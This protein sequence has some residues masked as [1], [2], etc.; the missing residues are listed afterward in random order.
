M[1]KVLIILSCLIILAGGLYYQYEKAFFLEEGWHDLEELLQSPKT[2]N[3]SLAKWNVTW[4]EHIFSPPCPLHQ[5]LGFQLLKA[6]CCQPDTS[7][8][9]ETGP[10]RTAQ[11]WI[12]RTYS[13]N[14]EG[15]GLAYFFPNGDFYYQQT[16]FSKA[17]RLCFLVNSENCSLRYYDNTA[18]QW[19]VQIPDGEPAPMTLLYLS[20]DHAEYILSP[21]Y[22]YRDATYGCL[23][24]VPEMD[25]DVCVYPLD[26]ET[27]QV[28]IT[29]PK[30]S[31][32]EERYWWLLASEET[33]VD[34]TN[35]TMCRLWTGYQFN[36]GRWCGTGFYSKKPTSYLPEG[37]NLYFLNP[38]SYIPCNF[39]GTGG[40]RAADDLGVT[41]LDIVRARYNDSYFIPI[42]TESTMLQSRY[43]IGAGYFD[44]R[45]N[46]DI[47]LAY[48]KAAEKFGIAEF[49]AT[50]E[51][52]AK[53]LFWHAE[54]HGFALEGF[55]EN[56]LLVPD[57]C[58][59]KGQGSSHAS[60]NH[61]LAEILFLYEM[62]E[63]Y[64]SLADKMLNGVKGV[65]LSWLR[66][67]GNLQYAVLADGAFWGNDY[68]YLTYND[69]YLLQDWLE[70]NLQ[71]KDGF[72]AELMQ[73]K[74]VW[75]DRNGIHG[76]YQN[77]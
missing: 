49:Y 53:F 43:G 17:G 72:L 18:A 8:D 4:Y 48:L 28:E 5:A 69:L 41:M 64:G 45:W 12:Y 73:E 14:E 3:A 36:K 27:W 16:T 56:A 26:A 23:E 57:Y 6:A 30:G 42:S 54:K 52:Y 55:T 61:M 60:L 25:G 65:G 67:D 74:K 38:A 58:N 66:E 21:P 33:L 47:A 2:G 71:E 76:Y 68:P 32:G 13:I 15:E 20:F 77:P 11:G 10:L 75:M 7:I 63:S 50:A 37:E 40:S 1:Q 46:T 62:G 44:T 19:V 9:Y 39:I 24:W 29:W 22:G 34:W 31:S 35:E 59:E 51:R 70:T